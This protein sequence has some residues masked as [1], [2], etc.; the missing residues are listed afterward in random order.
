M[1]YILPLDYDAYKSSHF[2][3]LDFDITNDSRYLEARL[4]YE[5]LYV[6]G[7]QYILKEYLTKPI[8]QYDLDYAFPI[9]ETLGTGFNKN[10]WEYIVNDLGG[11]LPIEIYAVNEGTVLPTGNVIMQ[12]TNTD[13]KCVWLAGLLE[14]MLM[15]VFYPMKVA[16][17][18]YNIK[19][20]ILKYANNIDYKLNDFGSRSCSSFETSGIGGMAHLTQFKG[21][22]NVPGIYFM[23]KY[24]G[25][26]A[27]YASVKATEHSIM[28]QRGKERHLEIV[29][30]IVKAY[31]NEITSIVIDAYDDDA[32]LEY[33]G[34]ILKEVVKQRTQPLVLRPDTGKPINAIL[35]AFN[36]LKK[37]FGT[38]I[39]NGK[40]LLPP[41]IR[42]IQG[43]GINENSIREILQT[44]DRMNIHIDNV[45]F[46]MGSSLLQNV[47][48]DDLR[49]AIKSSELTLDD[50]S[51]REVF[52]QP[53]DDPW[54][55]SK[56]GKLALV[57][58]NDEFVTIKET[59]LQENEENL[60]KLVYKNGKLMNEQSFPFKL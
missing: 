19:Q 30:K 36:S 14:T 31:P 22:D 33:I 45:C 42:I 1:K 54:K 39:I 9:L 15:R 2:D 60:L 37:N 7:L 57:K 50:G 43:D 25:Y 59:E 49:F 40:E 10:G 21:T 24:Y 38:E 28:T 18:S 13:P 41:Y 32:V 52:K 8:T 26:A 34:T 17:K 23:K 16:T 4:K 51:K 6:F 58:R 48:R 46:G 27:K 47:G 29:D 3:M 5:K 11:Y 12:Y 56:S 44:L 53:K 55:T 35:K 20:E